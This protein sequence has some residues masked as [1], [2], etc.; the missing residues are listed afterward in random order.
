M[1]GILEIDEGSDSEILS[2][3]CNLQPQRRSEMKRWMPGVQEKMLEQCSAFTFFDAMK[4]DKAVD[5]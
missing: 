4:D 1:D 3:F 5:A 2:G